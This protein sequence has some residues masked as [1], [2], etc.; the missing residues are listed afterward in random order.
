[1]SAKK[2]IYSIALLVIIGVLGFLFM[3]GFFSRMASPGG[4]NLKP[5][6]DEQKKEVLSKLGD[7]HA[8]P[9]SQEEQERILTSLTASSTA[10]T[11]SPGTDSEKENILK[12][13]QTNK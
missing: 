7:P 5:L 1:M 11:S 10:T 2:I 8:K 3:G 6:T 4:D 12:S 9:I 13:L